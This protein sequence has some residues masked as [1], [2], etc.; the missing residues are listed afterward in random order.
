MIDKAGSSLRPY[1]AEWHEKT[2]VPAIEEMH[3]KPKEYWED[4]QLIEKEIHI[5]LT[6]AHFAE[7]TE[8]SAKNIKDDFLYPLY[9]SGL[10]DCVKSVLDRRENLWF[11]VDSEDKA[12]SLFK[13]QNDKRL[14]ITE[15]SVYPYSLVMEQFTRRRKIYYAE[16]AMKNKKNISE[17]YS[18]QDCDVTEI[19]VKQLVDKYLSNPESCFIA[20]FQ[21]YCAPLKNISYS[22]RIT[23][24]LQK[25]YFFTGQS[26]NNK[27]TE[28]SKNGIEDSSTTTTGVS[29]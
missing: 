2:F 1:Q 15:P 4:G 3:G 27:F 5:G 28:F 24:D 25:K 6:A 21:R 12:F 14:T 10:I 18:L 29:D 26:P 16:I 17:I 19:S 8:E 23:L 20:G 7:R 22:K 13:D 9:N 11:S